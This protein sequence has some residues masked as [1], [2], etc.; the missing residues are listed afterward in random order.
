MRRRLL[1]AFIAFAVLAIAALEIPLGNTMSQRNRQDAFNQLQSTSSSLGL[2]ISSA[3]E[4]RANVSEIIA[5]YQKQTGN[6]LA[7]FRESKIEFAS[8]TEAAEEIYDK[9]VLALLS[10][11]EKGSFVVSMDDS[12]HD[13]N[14]LYS[15]VPMEQLTPKGSHEV[16]IVGESSAA[17]DGIIN[18]EWLLLSGI[19][20][21]VLLIAL[22]AAIVI[23]RSFSKPIISIRDGVKLI[24]T[25][26]ISYRLEG[27]KGPSEI[28]ELSQSINQ[29]AEQIANLL[30]TQTDFIADASHQ[31]RSPLTALRLRY[32]NL[33]RQNEN[34]DA[35]VLSSVGE[36][37]DRLTFLVDELLVLAR[38]DTAQRVVQNLDLVDIIEKQV[39]LWTALCEEK[40]IRLHF[41]EENNYRPFVSAALGEIEQ[42][43]NNLISN[44]VNVSPA[45]S[46]IKVL[47]KRNNN[48][49]AENIAELHIEDN[50]PGMAEE[51]IKMA[52]HRFWRSPGSA[53]HGSGLGLSVVEKLVKQFGATC[54]LDTRAEGGMDAVVRFPTNPDPFSGPETQNIGVSREAYV[55]KNNL[56]SKLS[57]YIKRKLIFKTSAKS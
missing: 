16:L 12:D 41:V 9:G 14:Y 39:I 40:K 20:I 56:F 17:L 8:S 44:A 54:E 25:E 21:L 47:I 19:G 33:L 27:I 48:S 43:F 1:I 30:Q 36:E 18:H 45:D 10:K 11:A 51:E 38:S 46:E 24:G 23:S 15:F 55:Q 37:L 31:L 35:N 26:N 34:C 6:Y 13:G 53:Y 29:M 22:M 42:V 4:A 5:H 57:G 49:S 28:N 7:V 52:F 3:L 32:E 50:G 2:I